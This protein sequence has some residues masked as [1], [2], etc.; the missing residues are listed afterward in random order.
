MLRA[1]TAIALATALCA[2]AAEPLTLHFHDRPPY[3][4]PAA[5][6][7]VGLVADPAARALKAAGIEYRWTLTPP[8]RQLALIEGAP[9]LHCGVG[10][11]RNAAREARGRF[12]APLYRDRPFGALV[13]DALP[14]ASGV[15]AADLV[16]DARHSALL[17]EGY[18]YG[19]AFDALLAG[20]AGA[21]RTAADPPQM[22]QMVRAG[23]AAWMIVAPEEAE[24][25][26]QPGLR[27][28]EF[29]D[30]PPGPT[31]H[32]YCNRAVPA[33]WLARVDRVLAAPA[34]DDHA[35]QA[36]R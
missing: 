29:R 4:A 34:R 30:V 10:W 1:V 18:S 16:A 6:R 28:V 23:R 17:K 19:A 15:R 24:V 35:A 32:L 3:S 36:A 25:L 21:V 5:D 14:I 7:A 31:R 20:A 27:F 9:G 11:F 13:R 33:D 26:Q 12:S 2:Q 22:A 8:R